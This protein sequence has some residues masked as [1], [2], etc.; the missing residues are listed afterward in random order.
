MM[1]WSIGVAEQD[2]LR[3]GYT[4]AAPVMH[5]RAEAGMKNFGA[6]SSAGGAALRRLPASAIP[7]LHSG[8]SAHRSAL[9]SPKPDDRLKPRHH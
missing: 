8:S 7:P 5:V 1:A 4:P 9:S 6:F 3:G 2:D